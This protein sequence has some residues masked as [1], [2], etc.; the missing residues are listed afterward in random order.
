MTVQL[1][2]SKLDCFNFLVSLN[3]TEAG[4]LRS[5]LET[6]V[7]QDAEKNWRV[8]YFTPSMSRF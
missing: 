1:C 3:L 6:P 2:G 8:T 4:G 7:G 5:C